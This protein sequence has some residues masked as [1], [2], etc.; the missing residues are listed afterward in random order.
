MTFNIIKIIL[1]DFE[2][3]SPRLYPQHLL[4]GTQFQCIVKIH[5][6]WG[7]PEYFIIIN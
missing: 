4:D 3:A 6:L 1:E 7:Y 5:Q 2:N